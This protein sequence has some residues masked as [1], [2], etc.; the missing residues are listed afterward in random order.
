MI[1]LLHFFASLL[2]LLLTIPAVAQCLLGIDAPG[3][4]VSTPR[5]TYCSTTW[6]PDGAGPQ[7]SVL[8]VG[9]TFDAAGTTLCRNVAVWNGTSWS[10]LGEG[11]VGLTEGRVNA[12]AVYNGELYAAGDFTLSGGTV[13]NRVARWS[14]ANQ[15]WMP[16][17]SGLNNVA[18]ALYVY[19]GRLI[20]GG[21]FTTAA[22]NA[23]NGLTAWNGSFF[24]VL[25]TG[26]QG[27]PAS[28]TAV[29]AMTQNS[30]FLY[31]AH[32]CS[33][34][35]GAPGSNRLARWN[36]SVWE[37]ISVSGPVYML[38]TWTHSITDQTKLF[39]GG[40]FA[41][42]GGLLI[43]NLAVLT[44]NTTWSSL[45]A[46][47]GGF[48]IQKGV[49]YSSGSSNFQIYVS[50]GS[51]YH[52][53]SSTGAWTTVG[54]T[55]LV[56]Q[57]VI[58]WNNVMYNVGLSGVYT[59]NSTY[60]RPVGP[61]VDG[62]VMDTALY[63]GQ[64]HLG[65]TFKT[66][67]GQLVNNITRFDGANYFPLGAGTNGTIDCMAEFNNQLVIG[68]TFTS[69]D[70]QAISGTA[71]WNG[72]AWS[73]MPGALAATR[74]L[75]VHD[76]QLYCTSYSNTSP[77][78]GG[79]F[80]W[81]GVSWA[82]LGQTIYGQNY[83]VTFW[84]GH[85]YTQGAL[86][87]TQPLSTLRLDGDTWVNI[88]T[89][90]LTYLTGTPQ[91]L[92]AAISHGAGSYSLVRY[93]GATWTTLLAHFPRAGPLFNIDGALWANLDGSVARWI[94]G[95]GGGNWQ[96]LTDTNNYVRTM[97][98][99]GSQYIVGGDFTTC[100]F[101][102]RGSWATFVPCCGSSDYN[103]D[104]D[105]GTDADIEAFFACLG[106]SC[107]A[108]VSDSDFNADGDIGTDADIEAFFRVLGGG[109]C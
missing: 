100:D 30:G 25:G 101:V 96:V 89:S 44:N 106:G 103:C 3:Q 39:V 58:L 22:G 13:V 59:W 85:F 74:S 78:T 45:P 80:R 36:G 19:G 54:S 86:V 46:Y 70:S 51:I 84:N 21:R 8:V 79:V 33:S 95:S 34:V 82:R 40:N 83:D 102:A 27:L 108:C 5:N 109:N 49:V 91:G 43:T 9:G 1:S 48:P 17:S 63:N 67:D 12:L 41:S 29:N 90:Q 98:R 7:T 94:E 16:L 24:T 92:F 32:N 72:A 52:Y 64:V 47:P 2:A 60:W 107:P 10:A 18:D 56:P 105:F 68:G 65:G 50:T 57:Q 99:H 104:G 93:D 88:N 23:V 38:G 69:V 62:L 14:V 31:V 61:G 75:V 11:L 37:G 81:N 77:V 26:M 55:S 97:R 73:A 76:G 4:E 35:G 15:Q 28:S 71:R 87:S 53:V 6:D 66:A 42:A 20:I